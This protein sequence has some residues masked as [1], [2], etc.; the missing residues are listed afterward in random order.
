MTT[1]STSELWSG[2]G[3]AK[4]SLPLPASEQ[5]KWPFEAPGGSDPAGDTV[6]AIAE[7]AAARRGPDDIPSESGLRRLLRFPWRR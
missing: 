1:N 7:Q 5:S 6:R 4:E 2:D 3:E